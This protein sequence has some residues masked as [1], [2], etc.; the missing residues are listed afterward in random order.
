MSD[1]LSDGEQTAGSAGETRIHAY[2]AISRSINQGVCNIIVNHTI[3]DLPGYQCRMVDRTAI[4]V[5]CRY[6]ALTPAAKRK[7]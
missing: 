5:L 3:V 7:K 6:E 2:K 1:V 4:G